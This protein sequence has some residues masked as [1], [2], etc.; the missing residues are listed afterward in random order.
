MILFFTILSKLIPL[1]ALIGLGYVAGKRLGV[2]KDSVA[3][4]LLYVI[5][6]V[7]VFQGA[8]TAELSASLLLLPI[9]FF[10]ISSTVCLVMYRLAGRWWQDAT[11]NLLAFA[12]S[13]A[14]TGYFGLPVA[15][16]LF[17]EQALSIVVF[18]TMGLIIFENTLG[19]FITARG[20]HTAS[21]ALKKIARL[22]TLYAFGIGILVNLSQVTLPPLYTEFAGYFRGAYSLLGMM[23]IGLAMST[24]TRLAFDRR[25]LSLILLTKFLVWPLLMFLVLRLD[26]VTFNIIQPLEQNILWLLATVPIAANTVSFATILKAHPDKAALAV[27]LSTLVGALAVPVYMLLLR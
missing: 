17:G 1:Y 26:D 5:V 12:A 18:T 7:V 15:I 4:L 6:P 27:L 24:V 16:L 8:Y 10:T 20:Q 22:P 11:K 2:Q 23:L 25:F 9:I 3:I 21:E 14:N 13:S 19:F